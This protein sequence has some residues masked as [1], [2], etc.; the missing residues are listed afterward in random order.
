MPLSAVLCSLDHRRSCRRDLLVSPRE[1]VA[2]S[3]DRV[4]EFKLV[5]SLLAVSVDSPIGSDLDQPIIR[6]EMSLDVA[7]I[8]CAEVVAKT[9]PNGHRLPIDQGSFP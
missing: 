5:S 2:Q 1:F 9:N 4:D 3:A 7:S 6:G 8:G